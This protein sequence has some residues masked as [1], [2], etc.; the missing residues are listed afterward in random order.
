MSTETREVIAF[1]A[2]AKQGKNLPVA[3]PGMIAAVEITTAQGT[4]LA[5]S[6][7][8]RA[9]AMAAIFAAADAHAAVAKK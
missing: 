3:V 6:S 2:T 1:F 4:F 9:R 8:Q 5:R 7:N